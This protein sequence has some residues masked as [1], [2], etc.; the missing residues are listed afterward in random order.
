[1]GLNLNLVLISDPARPFDP[2][3]VAHDPTRARAIL[4]K[5]GFGRWKHTGATTLMRGMRPDTGELRITAGS[6][7]T[8]VAEPGCL[9]LHLAKVGGSES[10]ERVR[11]V[12]PGSEIIALS[13]VSFTDTFVYTV[14]DPRGEVVRVHMGDCESGLRVDEGDLLE[15][16]LP[17]LGDTELRDGRRVLSADGRD[18]M[19][20]GSGEELVCDVAGRFFGRSIGEF[21]DDGVPMETYREPP[22]WWAFWRR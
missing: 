3:N 2:E 21:D 10:V 18:W 15:E 20:E 4:K 11:R 8:I 19:E 6:G 7:G 22:P 9:G 14:I 1:M 13:L 12:F 16:E 17:G 5:L